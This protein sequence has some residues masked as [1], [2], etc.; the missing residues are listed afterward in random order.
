MMMMDRGWGVGLGG[1][2]REHGG[3][4]KE[5]LTEE[6]GCVRTHPQHTLCNVGRGM[7]CSFVYS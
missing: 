4:R 3:T 5:V 1:L 7:K 6:T 2:D